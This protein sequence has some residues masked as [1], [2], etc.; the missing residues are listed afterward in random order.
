MLTQIQAHRGASAAAPENTMA[1]FELAG[2]MGADGVELD[3]HL[4]AD[5]KIVVI[6]DNTVDRTSDGT[7]AVR[8]LP[9]ARLRELDIS[10]GRPGFA[11]ARIPTLEEVYEFIRPTGMTVNVE[12]KEN[13]YDHGF[14]ILPQLLRLTERYGLADRVVYSSFNHYVLRELKQKLPSAETAILYSAAL[15]DVWQYAA[16]VPADGIHPN[17]AALEDPEVTP[18]CHAAGQAVRPWTV[19]GK[20]DLREMFRQRVDAVITNFPDRALAIR[21]DM[22]AG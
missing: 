2:R 3:V 21:R 15:V 20:S 12:I 6:H 7:G 14:L 5:D 9:F 4:T 17:F 19:N 13:A 18:R 16:M 1:A 11:G 8:E 10:M 22:Q